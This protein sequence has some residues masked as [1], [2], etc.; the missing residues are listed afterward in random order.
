MPFL[1]VLIHVP[2]E[3]RKNKS[4]IVT[5]KKTPIIPLHMANGIDENTP[6]SQ[7]MD[8]DYFLLLL[9]N[10]NYYVS[11]KYTFPDLNEGEFPSKR[12]FPFTAVGENTPPQPKHDVDT[13]LR[14]WKSYQENRGVPTSCWTHDIS[15]NIL[16]WKN[17][18]S[19]LG[20]CIKSS[21]RNV[22]ASIKEN[23]Y[24]IWCGKM[25]YNGYYAKRGFMKNMFSKVSAYSKEDECRFYFFEQTL[26]DNPLP[27]INIPIDPSIM[28]DEVSVSPFIEKEASGELVR[29]IHNEYNVNIHTSNIN[30]K[31]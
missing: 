23:K 4:I 30:I 15:N 21:V 20:V 14:V 1:I 27:Y 28:I 2:L 6:I 5:N 7:Y 25:T 16:M 29:L 12:I 3:G 13:C 18:T 22:I 19:K 11:R 10:K 24:D 31:L 8:L 26:P 9:K 17:F